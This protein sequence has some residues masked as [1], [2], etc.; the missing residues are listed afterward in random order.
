MSASKHNMNTAASVY[1][2]IRDAIVDGTF[3]SGTPLKQD[4]LATEFGVSKIPIR[5]AL[6][7]LEAD[8]FV[9]SFPGRG[10]IVAKLSPGEVEEIY[11][12]RLALEPILLRRSIAWTPAV[13]WGRADGVLT[14][15]ATGALSSS[16]WH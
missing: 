2:R 12:M 7:L 4:Q 10:A 11:L 16:E 9:E 8:G 15:L 3:Q 1:S 14:A 6:V 5:E 13:T